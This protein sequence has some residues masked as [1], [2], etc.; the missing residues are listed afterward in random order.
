LYTKYVR[1]DGPRST[2][3]IHGSADGATYIFISAPA[4]TVLPTIGDRGACCSTLQDLKSFF[5]K[6]HFLP[7]DDPY[8][9]Q[10]QPMCYTGTAWI[11]VQ[12]F[13][14]VCHA[15][16]EEIASTTLNYLVDAW[17]MP[18]IDGSVT[19]Q[20]LSKLDIKIIII[21]LIITMIFIVL[22]S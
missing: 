9:H 19:N 5:F 22:S 17:L 15:V 20:R 11:C 21:I 1:P 4:P 16:L 14:A 6:V 3:I 8:R 13:A 2:A 12:N 10:T 7:T 18:C